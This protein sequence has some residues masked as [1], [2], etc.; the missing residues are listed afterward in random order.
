MPEKLFNSMTNS[1]GAAA[2]ALYVNNLVVPAGT[3]LDLG[4]LHLYTRTTQINGIVIGTISLVPDSGPIL[5]DTPTSGNIATVGQVDEW[6][7]F[8]RAGRA[9][10]VIGNP[11]TTG[12]RRR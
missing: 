4:S 5:Y 2:E 6:T 9:V 12:A 10:T 11:G 1:P 8:G 7:F 3:T